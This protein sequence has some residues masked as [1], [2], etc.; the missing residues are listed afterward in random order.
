MDWQ[1]KANIRLRI[2]QGYPQK[3]FMFI[4]M[5]NLMLTSRLCSYELSCRIK[6]LA[7]GYTRKNCIVSLLLCRQFLHDEILNLFQGFRGKQQ[8][9]KVGAVFAKFIDKNAKKLFNSRFVFELFFE[10]FSLK[11]ILERRSGSSSC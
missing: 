3:R 11:H 10:F 2:Y 8:R 7:N 6:P 4:K 9:K 5:Q 1:N